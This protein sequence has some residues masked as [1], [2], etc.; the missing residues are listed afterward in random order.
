MENTNENKQEVRDF[1][2]QLGQLLYQSRIERRLEL[3]QVAKRLNADL[4]FFERLEAGRC[5]L[6]QFWQVMKLFHLYDKKLRIV[7]KDDENFKADDNQQI[8]PAQIA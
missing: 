8:K 3:S 2:K 1:S 4:R 7:I 5:S 6:S